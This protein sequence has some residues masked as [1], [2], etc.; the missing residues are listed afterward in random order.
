M[1]FPIFSRPRNLFYFD[2]LF[3]STLDV[4]DPYDEFDQLLCR[5]DLTWI[6]KPIFNQRKF[7]PTVPFKKRFVIDIQGYKPDTIDAEIKN[8]KL[9]VSGFKEDKVGEEESS[10]TEFRDLLMLPENL[11]EAKMV[12]FLTKTGQLIVEIPFKSGFF[13]KNEFDVNDNGGCGE[14]YY[15]F[16]VIESELKN[17]KLSVKD[18]DLII[19]VEELSQLNEVRSFRIITL[20]MPE[21][22]DAESLYCIYDD[23]S[24]KVYGLLKQE[25]KKVEKVMIDSTIR[26]T[27]ACLHVPQEHM[28][29]IR[30]IP[31][32]NNSKESSSE[33]EHELPSSPASSRSSSSTSKMKNLMKKLS[34]KM[35]N[36]PTVVEKKEVEKKEAKIEV[37]KKEDVEVI[38]VLKPIVKKSSK[39]KLIRSEEMTESVEIPSVVDEY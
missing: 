19:S 4:F 15:R 21:N 2:T 11:D 25:L 26:D 28:T 23:F 37:K 1:N 16:D 20:Q 39:K 8:G 9:I 30:I 13:V 17:V 32:E 33:H 5:S 10:R 35:T 31:K 3:D 18:F 24:L 36:K 34:F 22:A 12:S 14:I 7:R 38:E 29:Q 27:G 6:R